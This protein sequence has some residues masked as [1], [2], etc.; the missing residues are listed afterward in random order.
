L[1]ELGVGERLG[2][3]VAA[4]ARA[5]RAVMLEDGSKI[6]YGKLI[7]ATGAVPVIPPIPGIGASFVHTMWSL[8]DAVRFRA[9]L[10]G[11]SSVVVL[12]A[13]VLGVETAVDLAAAKKA[14]TL[15]EAGATVLSMHLGRIPASMY[16]G[17]LAT[18]GVSVRAST[19]IVSI[20]PKGRGGVAV[21]GDGSAIDADLILVMTGVAPNPSLAVAAGLEVDGG[22]VVDSYLGTS[23]PDILACGNCAVVHGESTM[24]W[25]AAKEQGRV[26]GTNAFERRIPAA[27]KGTSIHVKTPGMPLFICSSGRGDSR[28]ASEI[29]SAASGSYRGIWLDEEDRIAEGVFMCVL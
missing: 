19:T 4:V 23:D 28:K 13:G 1:R 26:A 29:V 18:A 15:V 11:A 5:E 12:G 14:V 2:A 20:E 16:Q 8:D 21:L 22:I 7:L 27:A 3:G 24:L 25:G 10:P 17:F 6:G 9:A